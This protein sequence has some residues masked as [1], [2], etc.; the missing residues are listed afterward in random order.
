MSDRKLEH[1]I[2]TKELN[3]CIYNKIEKKIYELENYK[4][5]NLSKYNFVGNCEEDKLI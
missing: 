3:M 5:N 1:I 2:R 4:L